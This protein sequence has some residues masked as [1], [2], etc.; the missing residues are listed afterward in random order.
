MIRI[1]CAALALAFLA[2]CGVP[3][4]KRSPCASGPSPSMSFV[5]GAG[6]ACDFQDF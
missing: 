2:S 4:G 5:S 6:H 1:L 3:T